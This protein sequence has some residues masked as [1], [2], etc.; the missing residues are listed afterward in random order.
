MGTGGIYR[1]LT[2]IVALGKIGSPVRPNIRLLEV[3]RPHRDRAGVFQVDRIPVVYWSRA[4]NKYFMTMAEGTLIK[5]KGRLETTEDIGLTIVADYMETLIP[6]R[7]RPN[8]P[9]LLSMLF[10]IIYTI[11]KKTYVSLH[12][13]RHHLLL[14]I[15]FAYFGG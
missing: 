3:E 10:G 11:R 12:S 14:D 9:L 4:V 15:L 1:M 2:T 8:N 6:P 7:V 13:R 5:I